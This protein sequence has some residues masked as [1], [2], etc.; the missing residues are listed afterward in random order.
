MNHRLLDSLLDDSVLMFEELKKFKVISHYLESYNYEGHENLKNLC[1]PF[2]DPKNRP[3]RQLKRSLLTA[4]AVGL[5]MNPLVRLIL[6]A[7]VPWDFLCVHVLNKQ[8]RILADSLPTW[9]Q[10]LAELEALMSLAN[11]AY[12]NPDDTFPEIISEKNFVFQAKDLGHP[13]LPDGQRKC[14]DFAFDSKSGVALITGS[15]MSGKSTFLKTIGINLCLAF[16]GGPVNAQHLQTSLFR[17]Y[18]SIKINDSVTDGFSFFYAE[19]RRLKTLLN[20]LEKDTPV[21]V[22]FLIDEIFKGTNNRE[23]YIGGRSF[24]QALVGKNGLGAVATHDLELTKLA[25]K[26]AN[27]R[28]YHFKEHVE[29]GKMVFDYKLRPGPCP[30][31]NALKIMRMEGLPVE[32]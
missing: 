28:N 32:S 11:F 5:R 13:L 14:N 23:R 4:T 2:Q 17:I 19:V 8:K 15:N 12:L 10:I 25:D 3:S 9:L 16:A 6:N 7:P 29:Q 1:Q 30:T 21:P 26:I 20:E 18:T 24:I 31:T 27:V 22:L